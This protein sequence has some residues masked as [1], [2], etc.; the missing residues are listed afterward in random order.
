MDDI[1]EFVVELLLEIFGG[2]GEIFVPDNLSEKKR[3]AY[4]ALFSIHGLCF[5]ILLLVGAYLTVTAKNRILGIILFAVG[6]LYFA[7]L[8]TFYCKNKSKRG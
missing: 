3:K 2:I 1:I 8:I 4:A 6:L 5:G 7:F